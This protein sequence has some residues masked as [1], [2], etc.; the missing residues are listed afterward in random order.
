M[1]IKGLVLAKGRKPNREV[2]RKIMEDKET[3]MMVETELHLIGW[4]VRKIIDDMRLE[5]LAMTR[6]LKTS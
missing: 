2:T 1:G 6:V 5:R 3:R 4:E